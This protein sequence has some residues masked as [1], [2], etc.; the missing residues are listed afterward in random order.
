MQSAAATKD[1]NWLVGGCLDQSVRIWQLE[2]KRGGTHVTELSCGGYSS[3]VRSM[4]VHAIH[5][6]W[7]QIMLVMTSISLAAAIVPKSIIGSQP[8]LVHGTT[9]LR[10][11]A[12]SQVTRVDF[13]HDGS[14][15]ASVAGCQV[16]IWDFSGK[17]GPAS[18]IPVVALGHSKAI[19]CQVCY[20]WALYCCVA[21]ASASTYAAS[22]GCESACGIGKHQESTCP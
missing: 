11:H 20:P 18:T 1:L 9:P 21:D 19:T 22:L 15:L 3:K 6:K 12:M 5:S 10:C 2:H 14:R 4:L 16:T 17:G 7:H 8:C 13:S